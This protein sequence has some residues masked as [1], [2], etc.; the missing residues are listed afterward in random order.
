MFKWTV[1][2]LVAVVVFAPFY[3]AS[4][5]AL[6]TAGRHASPKSFR[7][8]KSIG[9]SILGW[10]AAYGVFVWLSPLNQPK[11]QP[12]AILIPVGAGIITPALART[13]DVALMGKSSR[14]PA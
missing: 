13:L 6:Q 11:L 2:T 14:R 10:Y 9:F 8:L 12:W 3:M 4:I 1:A 5:L 7:H